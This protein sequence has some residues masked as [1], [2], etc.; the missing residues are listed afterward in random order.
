M[1]YNQELPEENI[2]S[3]Q[4]G[5]FNL[6]FTISDLRFRTQNPEEAF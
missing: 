2:T 1:K 4:K 3:P 6:R 5:L